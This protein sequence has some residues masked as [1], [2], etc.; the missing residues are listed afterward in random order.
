LWTVAHDE[1]ERQ[2]QAAR[3]LLEVMAKMSHQTRA[4]AGFVARVMARADALAMPRPGL[5]AW[6][7]G[8]GGWLAAG[9][10]RVAV[11]ALLVLA[12]IGAVPQYVTWIKAFGMGV[13][14]EVLHEARMQENL[15]E[16]NFTCATQ[17]DRRSSN[18]AAIR[19]EH[20]TVVTWACPSGDVLVTVESAT[21]DVSRRSVWIPL[22]S[23]PQ[24]ISLFDLA[25]QDAFA[26]ARTF[27]VSKR[28]V[29]MVTVLCQ[30][31]LPNRFIKRRVQLA[32]GSCFDEVINPRTGQVVRRQEAPCDRAC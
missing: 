31:W 22:D 14:A 25:V 8:G 15:W 3:D 19:G 24:A 26:A 9:G 28:S 2:E 1:L 20:V 30:K 13:P 21:D 18:Y 11:A 5:F 29:P 4:S 17:L 32:N 6:L 12:L 16:K 27:R 10:A 7:T 23:R